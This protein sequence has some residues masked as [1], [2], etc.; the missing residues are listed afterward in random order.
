M[1]VPSIIN[2]LSVPVSDTDKALAFYDDV[3]PTIGAKRIFEGHGAVAYGKMFPEFWVHP[4]FD[5]EAAAGNG[6]HVAFMAPSKEAVH[7]F[8]E[9]A[10]GAGGQCDGA[11]GARP[12]YGPQYYGAFVRDLDGNKIEA[13]FWDESAGA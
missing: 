12:Q 10:L 13:S 5:G 9:K 3:L 2:H 1:D 6:W 11:P 7:A 8:H 4:P